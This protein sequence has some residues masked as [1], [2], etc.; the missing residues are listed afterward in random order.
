MSDDEHA[1]KSRFLVGCLVVV[2]VLGCAGVLIWTPLPALLM[3][4]Q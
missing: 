2:G 3:M 1:Q 4:W